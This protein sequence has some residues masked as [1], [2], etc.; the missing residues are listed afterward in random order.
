[1]VRFQL[2]DLVDSE[3]EF[4]VLLVLHFLLCDAIVKRGRFLTE[5]LQ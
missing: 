2:Y 5:M 1:M 4:F 3:F